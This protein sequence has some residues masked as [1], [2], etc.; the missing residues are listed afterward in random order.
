MRR[1]IRCGSGLGDSLYLQGAVRH[2]VA[3]GAALEVCTDW[4][5]VFRPLAGQVLVSP[6][7]RE[8]DIRA[9]YAPRKRIPGTD[10]F[11]DVCIMAGIRGPVDFRLDWQPQNLALIERIRGDG[12]WPVVLV[13]LPRTPMDRKDGF[14]D[15]LL[16]ARGAMQ[17]SID[18]L[19]GR[20]R[21]VQVGRGD[22]RYQLAGID[23]DLANSTGVADLIDAAWS[24]DG[25][26]GYVS[27]F[28]PLAESLR[29]PALFVWSRRGLDSPTD[30]IA[31]ITPRKILHRATS[32]HVIDD[33]GADEIAR[34][35]GEFHL[36]LGG[37]AALRGEAGGDRGLRAG[38]PR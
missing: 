26:L 28:V 4:P 29:K 33:C 11:Q 24:A 1:S 25:F 21:L 14:G 5:D 3:R 2:L 32:R 34:A 37:G 9:H 19:R 31:Q 12:R 17:A 6:F 13:L 10:Q 20:A 35:V 16:P 23:L 22:A 7:R 8:V 38:V 30:F 18:A 36:A 27:F 15:A